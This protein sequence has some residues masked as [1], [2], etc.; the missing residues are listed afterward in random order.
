VA[1]FARENGLAV[2]FIRRM[3]LTAGTFQPVEGG[4]GGHCESCNRLRLSSDGWL[5]PCLLS[6]LR[7]SV[8]ELG[9]AEAI[10]RGVEAKPA[11]GTASRTNQMYFVGG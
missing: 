11:C 5:R 10:R 9:A 6:D 4:D 2:R 8:R 3:E 7:F 1:G